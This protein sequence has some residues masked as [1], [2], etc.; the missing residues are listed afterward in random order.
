MEVSFQRLLIPIAVV[1]LLQIPCEKLEAVMVHS[2]GE[3]KNFELVF[4]WTMGSRRGEI[5]MDMTI[6][7]TSIKYSFLYIYIYT[8]FLSFCL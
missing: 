5:L 2:L 4:S 3:M 6:S 7:I 1:Y 8:N